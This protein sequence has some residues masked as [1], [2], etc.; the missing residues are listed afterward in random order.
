MSQHAHLDGGRS[1]VAPIDCGGGGVSRGPVQTLTEHSLKATLDG[2][3]G[4]ECAEPLGRECRKQP[5]HQAAQ[6]ADKL[7]KQNYRNTTGGAEHKSIS[8]M[9]HA[10]SPGVEVRTQPYS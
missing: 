1:G 2:S 7:C 6:P 10:D 4:A 8:A 3:G 9:E 5:Q